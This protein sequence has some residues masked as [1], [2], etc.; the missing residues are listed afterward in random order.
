DQASE[1]TAA[2]LDRLSATTAQEE[3]AISNFVSSL[4]QAKN[5]F[6]HDYIGLFKLNETDF[7]TDLITGGT[8]TNNGATKDVN[9]LDFDG[10]NDNYT[11]TF[12]P[13]TARRVLRNKTALGFFVHE[14]GDQTNTR[15]L[16]DCRDATH[17]ITVTIHSA[18]EVLF[19]I[20]E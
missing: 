4:I 2:I 6:Q 15:V 18:G 16:A 8:G 11:T 1:E 9:G 3:Q 5:F 13:S 17:R 19:N 14:V 20:N 10:V 12:N 7:N